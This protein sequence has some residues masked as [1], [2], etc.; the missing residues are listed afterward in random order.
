MQSTGFSPLYTS[1]LV[2][3]SVGF[4]TIGIPS[5]KRVNGPTYLLS[6]IESILNTTTETER[7]DLKVVVFLADTDVSYNIQTTAVILKRYG[8]HVTS[9][10]LTVIRVRPEF[11]PPLDGLKRNFDDSATRVRWRSKQVADYALLF[12]FS[13]DLSSYY[14]QL[15]DDVTCSEGFVKIIEDYIDQRN[16]TGSWTM[17]EFSELGFIGKLFRTTE[18]DRLARYMLMF[19][20]EQPV[21]WLMHSYRLS[22]GQRKVFLRRPTLFQHHGL[23]S[24]F[25]HKKDNKLKDR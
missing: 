25:D 11:Y 22:T 1:V 13:R 3:F 5:V 17:L 10:L 2:R 12:A 16:K 14:I 23:R 7:S 20:E 9:G 21:D 18:L 6:T 19:Y 24:S 8:G 4:L 15:E